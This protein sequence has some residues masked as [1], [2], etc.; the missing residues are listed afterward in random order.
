M[1]LSDL[2][3]CKNHSCSGDLFRQACP[4]K[5]HIQLFADATASKKKKK[6]SE[7]LWFASYGEANLF[8]HIR[9]AFKEQTKMMTHFTAKQDQDQGYRIHKYELSDGRR[10][11]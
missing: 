2:P 4:H 3:K 10:L 7:S 8:C 6:V 9:C 5:K 1:D 11:A